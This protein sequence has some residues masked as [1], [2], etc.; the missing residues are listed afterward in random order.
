MG[1]SATVVDGGARDTRTMGINAR[2]VAR[3]G[4]RRAAV[5][6]GSMGIKTSVVDG[7]ERS[8]IR[9]GITRRWAAL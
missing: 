1:I 4:D 6:T 3:L 2:V 8:N 7:G 5:D 9:L